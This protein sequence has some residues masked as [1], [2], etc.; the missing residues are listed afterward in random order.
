MKVSVAVGGRGEGIDVPAKTSGKGVLWHNQPGKAVQSGGLG[1]DTPSKIQS[2]EQIGPNDGERQ[3]D[4]PAIVEGGLVA[5]EVTG[6][7]VA[8]GRPNITYEAVESQ[9]KDSVAPANSTLPDGQEYVALEVALESFILFEGRHGQNGGSGGGLLGAAWTVIFGSGGADKGSVSKHTQ[10]GGLAIRLETSEAG[11]VAEAERIM[12]SE[13]LTGLEAGASTERRVGETEA[14]NISLN[15]HSHSESGTGSAEG[16]AMGKEAA[17]VVPVRVATA[18]KVSRRSILLPNEIDTVLRIN[19]LGLDRVQV[20][21]RTMAVE[22]DV[23]DLAALAHLAAALSPP[24]IAITSQKSSEGTRGAAKTGGAHE[25]ERSEG[26]GASGA[27]KSAKGGKN[28]RHAEGTPGEAERKSEGKS[29]EKGSED[30]EG[31]PS[32]PILRWQK[33]FQLVKE[34]SHSTRLH[35]V[36]EAGAARRR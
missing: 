31:G 36:L 15:V 13:G 12:R 29:K 27:K 4:G 1:E 11:E 8:E 23:Q 22:L 17:A 18:R 7:D 14:T 24:T 30:E 20:D 2:G 25:T 34:Q 10:L 33:A 35:G 28:G 3:R 26:E 21:A 5:A 9:I 6:D 16:V 19:K 32:A